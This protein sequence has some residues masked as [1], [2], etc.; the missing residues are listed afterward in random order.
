VIRLALAYFFRRPVQLLAILGVGIGLLA[1]LVVLAVMNGLIYEDRVSVRGPLGDLLLIPPVTETPLSYVD[2]RLALEAEEAILATAPH[3]IAYALLG[4]KDG[5]LRMSS[6]RR[7]DMNGV[8]LV[9]IDTDAET[10]VTAHAGGFADSLANA[11]ASPVSPTQPFPKPE[12]PFARPSVLVSDN[13]ARTL[14]Q[15]AKGLKNTRLQFAALPFRLPPQ[16]EEIIP[17]NADFTI[18]GT[19]AGSDYEMSLDRI[20]LPRTGRYGLQYNLTG[21]QGSDFSEIMLKLAPGISFADGKVA[22]LHALGQA[23]LPIPSESQGGSLQTWEER[24]SLFLSAID[25]ERRV[26]TLIM[27]FIVI[28]ASFGLFATLSAL[29]REKV[30][31]LGVLAAIGFSPFRRGALLFSLG[32]VASAVGALSGWAGAK[33]L[34]S[35]HREVET[36]L[37]EYWGI[38]V[39]NEQLYVVQGLPARWDSS[40]AFFLS[41]CAFG[42]GLLFSLG[43]SIRA[44]RLS[45]MEALRYE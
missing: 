19:Y 25:N 16:G 8:Q 34:V 31:D 5:D 30:R 41:L 29:V 17:A 11:H 15:D 6:T 22:V 37:E 2:Y 35:H 7:S 24:R 14:P 20:Y 32:T 43:P 44:A 27:F 4:L 3:L 40:Q 9:G 42:V 18:G 28:V 38:Q 39:F 10:R 45:P 13:L 1:L 23:G 12:G 26:V 33:W 36:F 21:E